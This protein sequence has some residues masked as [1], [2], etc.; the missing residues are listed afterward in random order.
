MKKSP[1]S[2]FAFHPLTPSRWGD[3]EELFGERGACGGCWCMA[4]RLERAAF[5]KGKGAGN[6]AAMKKLVAFG[7]RPGVL[8]YRGKRAVGWCAVAPRAEYSFLA[9]SRVLAPLD[10]EPVWS[11]SCFFVRRDCRRRGLSVRLLEAAVEFARKQGARV[12][13]GYPV[14]APQG[15]PAAFVWTGLE[16]TFLRAG[17]HEAARRSKARPVMRRATGA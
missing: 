11:V 4:W 1:A 8:A 14:V 7:A 12:V 9:R 16:G 6:R 13:E 17:F 15:Q 2:E 10:D 3:F 5:E